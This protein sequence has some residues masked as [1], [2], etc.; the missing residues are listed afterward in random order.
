MNR[1][2]LKKFVCILSL[3]TFLISFTVSFAEKQKKP[4]ESIELSDNIIWIMKKKTATVKA[5]VLPNDATNKKLKWSSS[6]ES[7]AKV[8]NGKISAKEKGI[9]DIVV[10]PADGSEVETTCKVIVLLRHEWLYYQSYVT[11]EF[12]EHRRNLSKLTNMEDLETDE[13]RAAYSVAL[14]KEMIQALINDNKE[15]DAEMINCMVQRA[16]EIG[17]VYIEEQTKGSPYIYNIYSDGCGHSLMI[18]GGGSIG[19]GYDQI[20]PEKIS[21]TACKI[22]IDLFNKFEEMDYKRVLE[23][24][25]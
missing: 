17:E 23:N 14:Y 13:I 15:L 11:Y 3:V 9:C 19:C 20:T 10:V 2:H 6:D 1:K 5:A 18:C 25:Y 7:V 24:N 16:K 8:S 12:M 21:K 22:D 4:V